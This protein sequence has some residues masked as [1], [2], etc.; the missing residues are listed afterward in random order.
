ML[1]EI[2]GQT[3]GKLTMCELPTG[4]GKSAL[5]LC[6]GEM[7]DSPLTVINTATIS[8]Q[9]QYANDFP[10]VLRMIGRSNFN[11]KRAPVTASE[12]P[13]VADPSITC[14]SEYHQQELKAR[15]ARS[16]ATN[17]AL[18]LSTL[19]YGKRLDARKAHR[20][21]LKCPEMKGIKQAVD[22]CQENKDRI[23][24]RAYYLMTTGSRYAKNWVDLMRQVEQVAGAPTKGMVTTRVGEVFE[25]TPVWPKLSAKNLLDSADHLLVMSAT[26]WG[27]EFF[28]ELLGYKKKYAYYNAPSPFESWRW[29]V[30]Y[31]P[32]VS[33]NKDSKPADWQKMS[34]VCHEYMHGRTNDK[35]IIH[36]ASTS[37]AD[38]IGRAIL[39]CPSCRGRLVLNRRG[40][41]RAETIAKFRGLDVG[42]WLIH[43]SVGEG[44]SFDDDQCRIQLVAKIRYPDLSDP[45][46]SLRANDGGLGKKFYFHSTAAYTAQTVGRGMRHEGDYCETY[47]LDGS[48]GNL[49]DQNRRAFPEWFQRQLR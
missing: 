41:G 14:D 44:E 29:P 5:A 3:L 28:A 46:V 8:L 35:G 47:I 7:L 21:G 10:N 27:G 42:A 25:A 23:H 49:Y 32:V 37:Q 22:W 30:Y 13:C 48:F 18:Y 6:L 1:A 20:L 4:T 11:C 45:L 2:T 33:L 34:E 24:R 39:R 15:Y 17:Y 12:A 16:I 9:D 26:L 38:A 36:V 19:M 43:S 31:R 40:Y